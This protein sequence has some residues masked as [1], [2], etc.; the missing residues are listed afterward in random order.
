MNNP[1]KLIGSMLMILFFPV[2]LILQGCVVATKDTLILPQIRSLF[3][4]AYEVDPYMAD[5]KP[6]TIAVLPFVNQAKS[7]NGSEAVRRGFYNHFSSLPFKDMELHRVDNLLRKAGLEDPAVIGKTP[8]QDLG[9][10]LNVDAVIYGTISDFDKLFAVI[11]SNVSVGAEIKM[12]DTKTGKMLWRGKHVTYIHEGG[13]STTPFGLVA[14]VIATAMNVRDIQLLRACDDLFREM[15]KTI[16]APTIADALRPPV[17]TLLVQD[18]KNLPKKSGDEIRVVIQGTPKM[19]A[20]FH[21]GEFKKNID[22]LEQEG[23]PGVY[24][25]VYKVIPGD[26]V[27]NA[28]ITGFLRDDAGNTAEWVDAVG[29]VT[30]DTISPDKLKKVNTVGRNNLVLLNWEKSPAPDLAGYRVYRSATPLSG[31]EEIAG[32][33]FSELR[34]EKLVNNQKYYYQVSAVDRA[35]NESEKSDTVMGMPVAPGPTPVSGVIETDTTWY[36]G[37][38]PYIIDRTVV[39]R[40]KALL[41]IEPGTEIRSRG[42]GL[43]IEGRLSAQGDDGHIIRF[44][45]LEAGKPWEGIVFNNVK[46][47]ENVLRYCRISNAS[48]AVTCRAASPRINSCELTANGTAIRIQGTFSK[49]EVVKNTIQK[50]TEAAILI[51]AGAQPVLTENIIQDN[52]REGIRIKSASPVIRNNQIRQNRGSGI[53]ATNI[54]AV[55]AGNNLVD[56]KP[57]DM[58]GEMT[59]EAVNALDNWWGSVQGLDILSRIRGKI[60]IKSVLNAPYPEGKSVELPILAPVLGG[61][62]KGDAFLILANSPY[63]VTRD[64]VIDGGATLY[65]EPG[66]AIQFDQ[67]TAVIAQDGGVMAKG[68]RDDPIVFTASAASPVPGFYV[69][70]VKFVKETKVNSAF[71]YCIVKYASVAFDIWFGAPEISFCHVAQN[72]QSG[73]YARNSST[74]KLLYNTFSGNRGEGA[75]TCVG[76]SNPSIHH[77]NFVENE[78]AIQTRS[79]IYIDARNNWWGSAPPDTSYIFGDLDRN[80]NIKPWLDAPEGKAFRERK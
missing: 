38:S 2:L 44:E 72:A 15:V 7:Q 35:G 61:T 75:I 29:S 30:L 11:Y 39:V 47:K 14:T 50:N 20:Y 62:L 21:I 17:I 65:I 59:G 70:A 26:N 43:V 28:V 51:E 19:Q 18:T 64:V 4:G 13:I 78:V 27:S 66:V 68:T 23:E 76:M 37:A 32:M 46:E 69:S 45:T 3:E 41:T 53:T 24:L 57:F 80:I 22:M 77:N 6:R 12:M 79:T 74:P 10:I 31:F 73:V 1:L 54:Q 16:P 49:P 8:P 40:D 9:K 33:E 25:G 67:N 5:H 52:D 60:N 58:A 63:R 34:D 71:A 56:N 42:G 55:I 48:T 36:A